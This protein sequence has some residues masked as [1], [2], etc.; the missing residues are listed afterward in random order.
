M[1]RF[2]KIV[3]GFEPFWDEINTPLME[4]VNQAFYTK[5]LSISQR[6]AVIKLNEKKVR[7]KRYKKKN[8]RSSSLVN[9]DIK[10]LPNMQFH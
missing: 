5:I 10:I 9:G 2:P 3:N 1:E 4:I 8:L 6:Q 7:D